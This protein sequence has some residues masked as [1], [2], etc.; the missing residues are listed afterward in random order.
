MAAISRPHYL[1]TSGRPRN[2]GQFLATLFSEWCGGTE[3]FAVWKWSNFLHSQAQGPRPPVVVNMDETAVRLH[4]TW[5]PGLITA[6]ARKLKRQPG[7]LPRNATRGEMRT[8]FTLLALVCNDD[9]IQKQLPQFLLFSTATTNAAERDA[10]KSALPENVIMWAETR[11]WT[12]ETLMIRVAT[13]LAKTFQ[14]HGARRQI[15]LCCDAFRAHITRGVWKAMARL[16]IF[17]M[18]IPAKMTWALQPCDT[19]V[20]AIFKRHLAE[21]S[22][23]A[24]LS[25]ASG[26]VGLLEMVKLVGDAIVAVLRGRSWAKAFADIGLSGDQRTVSQRVLRKLGMDEQPTVP[27]GMPTLSELQETW[28]ERTIIPVAFIFAAVVRVLQGDTPSHAIEPSPSPRALW[29]KRLRSRGEAQ[30]HS[31]SIP[32][33]ACPMTNRAPPPWMSQTE[34]VPQGRLLWKRIIATEAAEMGVPLAARTEEAA[35]MR[36]SSSSSSSHQRPP[37]TS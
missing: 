4:Q 16:N 20:F 30:S 9:E 2:C 34:K 17:Y 23:R 1:V 19:H 11:A 37:P 10:V 12:T 28:P 29:L 36:S 22:Q 31:A 5:R 6:A 14:R 26:R 18:L 7:S 13:Q 27:E 21:Q 25:K 15:I 3:A 24:A 35:P 32:E 33:A 8:M